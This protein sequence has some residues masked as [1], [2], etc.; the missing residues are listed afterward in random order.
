[1]RGDRSCCAVVTPSGH[2]P[3]RGKE[4]GTS[5]AEYSF[6]SG[7]AALSGGGHKWGVLVEAGFFGGGIVGVSVAIST[8]H[9]GGLEQHAWSGLVPTGNV[10][11]SS[12]GAL[13]FASGSHLAPVATF[14]VSFKP[15]SHKTEVS[16]CKSGNQ[17]VYTGTVT[18]TISLN[19]GLKGLKLKGTNVKFGGTSTLTSLAGCVQ[20]PCAFS[21]WDSSTSQRKASADGRIISF[22]GQRTVAITSV[23]NVVRLPGAKEMFRIDAYQVSKAPVPKFDKPAKSLSINAGKSG[24]LTGAATLER[25]KVSG[26]LNPAERDCVFM[27]KKYTA[28]GTTYSKAKY[29]ASKQFVAHTILDGTIKVNPEGTADFEVVTLKKR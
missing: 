19:T 4:P 15:K 5:F 17:V 7:L 28:T 29:A 14:S 6:A 24:L 26:H 9:L 8:P 25:G 11:I 16:D 22:P 18:G 12:S 10:S 3:L 2:S 20:A 27:G 23:E 13:T 21:E 1:M